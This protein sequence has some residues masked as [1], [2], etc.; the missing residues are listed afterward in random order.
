LNPWRHWDL[1]LGLGADLLPVA[2]PGSTP[3]PGSK[4]KKFGKTPSVI[5]REGNAHG[6]K[7]WTTRAIT[8]ENIQRWS[9][10][11]RLGIC[12]RASACR[13]IDVDITAPELAQEISDVLVAFHF[14][15]RTRANSSKF[16]CPF[17][18]AGE[19]KKRI[20]DCGDAGRVEFLADG[21]QWLAAGTHESGTPYVWRGGLPCEIPELTAAEFE[22][23]WSELKAKFEVGGDANAR[24]LH[25]HTTTG[26]VEPG[27]A[28]GDNTLLTEIDE[29]TLADLRD[30]LSFKPLVDAALAN[31]VWSEV[32]YA[33]LSIDAQEL[34]CHFSA[35]HTGAAPH[36]AHEWWAA[37]ATQQPRSDYRHIFT[38]ARRLG[39][40]CV[41]DIKAFP[42]VEPH[43]DLFGEVVQDPV[44]ELYKTLIGKLPDSYHRT[45]DLANA[46]RLRDAFGGKHLVVIGGSFYAWSGRVWERSESAA[47]RCAASLPGLVQE[48]INTLSARYETLEA[49]L[50]AKQ[51][52]DWADVQSVARRD[53]SKAYTAFS[54]SNDLTEKLVECFERLDALR[55]WRRACEMQATQNNAI[56]M[57]R[58]L[59]EPTTQIALD[60]DRHLLNC[61][62]GTIDLRTGE[63]KRHDPNDFITKIARVSYDRAAHADRFEK[64]LVEIMDGDSECAAF[65]QRWF[66]YAATGEIREQKMVLHIGPG[67]NGKSTLLSAIA[68]ALGDYSHAAPPG[69]L[70]APTSERHPTEIADLAGRRLVTAHESDEGAVL[71][72]ALLKQATGGDRLKARFMHHDFFEFDPTHKLQ[73]LTNHKP[74]VRGQD[75]A[76]WRRLLLVWYK[77]G[78]GSAEDVAAGRA[79]RL[80]DTSLSATLE[81]ERAGIF[82]WIVQGAIEWYAGGLR[83]PASVISAGH[84]YQMEQDRVSQF[85][86]EC[87]IVDAQAWSPYNGQ[88]GGIYPE[89]TRW[90]RESGYQALGIKKFIDE[91]E[92]AVPRF[93]RAEMKRT[94][95][96]IRKTVNGCYGLKVNLD[97]DGG[98]VVEGA[99][100][101]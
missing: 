48:E 55:K 14:P 91:L 51:K 96:G 3:S 90:C 93:Q 75:F 25:D 37:H 35:Q 71:R 2:P 5:D 95:D 12:V 39:W 24:T 74:T 47:R 38:M 84:A 98:G 82:N 73:L 32:G 23:L 27:D 66:G 92:R 18:L 79:R 83:P 17:K 8:E 85:V 86:G 1:V 72:E 58:F 31:D 40:R 54:T 89:Y 52:A 57:L 36:A 56:A 68:D 60:K 49:Q 15:Y 70:T 62:N 19:W 16:L 61:L 45:T 20:I 99:D 46:H 63:I 97:N 9:L 6:L 53:Q 100:L 88:F 21:Q 41:A 26:D 4:I 13:A 87:C 29:A 67:A 59:L 28:S 7:D 10:D 77:V 30:A 94:I 76:I 42:V 69:L 44:E 80:R 65:L 43:A 101:L 33:L 22:A 50:D 34:F 78:F 64:F 81:S 11:E